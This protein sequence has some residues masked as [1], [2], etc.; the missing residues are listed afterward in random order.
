MAL[1][2]KSYFR[3]DINLPQ[4]ESI[5]QSVAVDNAIAFYEPEI[6]QKLLG[7][8][9]WKLLNAAYLDSI[10]SPDPVPLPARFNTLIN[11]E[12]FTF[13]YNGYSVTTK[14]NGLKNTEMI[15]IISYYVYYNY[16]NITESKTTPTGEAKPKREN[17]NVYSSI[18][19][20][21]YA[22][23]RM[24]ELYGQTPKPYEL[25]YD[26][27]KEIEDHFRDHTNY[28]HYNPEASAYNYLLANI[29]TYPEWIFTPLYK[30][31]S[32]LI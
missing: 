18:P 27:L 2:T 8:P 31:N 12:E 17:S 20:L 3:G 29:A 22:W 25:D 14:W 10:K 26:S 23:N 7:Y 9:L 5:Y 24:I 11:G 15:S 13:T 28:I 6:L 32:F 16:R 21:V 19:K 30:I 1:I 4:T